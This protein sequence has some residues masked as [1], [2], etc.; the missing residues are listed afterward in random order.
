M[1]YDATS[2]L[3]LTGYASVSGRTNYP[4]MFKCSVPA[5]G[6]I[7]GKNTVDSSTPYSN[8]TLYLKFP[9]N[10]YVSLNVSNLNPQSTHP[11][12]GTN[13]GATID[14]S[15]TVNL[16]LMKTTPTQNVMVVN[17]DTATIN[18]IVLA[19][20]STGLTVLQN[21]TRLIADFAYFIFNW[22]WPAHD[23]D[24]YYK[25]LQIKFVKYVT[26]CSF[27]DKNKTVML[28]D[29]SISAL[30]SGATSGKKAFTLNFTCS[31]LLNGVTTRNLLAFMSSSNLLGSD[32]STLI[33]SAAGSAGG[34]GIRVAKSSDDIPMKFSPSATAQ[35]AATPLFSYISNQPLEQKLSIPMNAWYYVYDQKALS[36]GPV[37]T[38]A[39]VNF[40]Y[41]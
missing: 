20:D 15:F 19:Q 17:G 25:P 36:S 16:A 26:T 27:D 32:N 28:N 23:Y 6:I 35:G 10:A 1:F 12:V 3:N 5:W 21:I 9:G 31:D 38:T 39:V 30:A 18:P 7:G 29:I 2:S 8:N 4:G 22:R 34:V 37:R 33:S 11:A 13:G 40:V 41:D 14:A 24:I